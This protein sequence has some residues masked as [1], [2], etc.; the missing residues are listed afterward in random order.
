MLF[1]D[2]DMFGEGP[3]PEPLTDEQYQQRCETY[4]KL[5]T[6][7][8]ARVAKAFG[9]RQVRRLEKEAAQFIDRNAM[10]DLSFHDWSALLND[11]LRICCEAFIEA[12]VKYTPKKYQHEWTATELD[13]L[14]DIC[15]IEENGRYYI[16]RDAGLPCKKPERPVNPRAEAAAV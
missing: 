13:R 5:L 10:L 6:D 9:P 1:Y 8:K 4:D 11:I 12:K 2:V 15:G 7:Y 16:F 14:I 3:K